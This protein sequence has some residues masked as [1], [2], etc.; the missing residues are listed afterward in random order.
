MNA[1]AS[2]AQRLPAPRGR[3]RAPGTP[4]HRPGLVSAHARA[5]LVQRLPAPLG[6]SCE[7]DTPVHRPGSV[8]THA[9]ASLAQRLPAIRGSPRAPPGAA[10]ARPA[11]PP[12]RPGS[13]KT[14]A[15]KQPSATAVLRLKKSRLS[16]PG[17]E[18]LSQGTI[19][20]AKLAYGSWLVAHRLRQGGRRA[21]ANARSVAAL[22]VRAC[23]W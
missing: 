20:A 18:K 3:P 17:T 14:H 2:L 21:A 5:S 13:V 10:P 12:H 7:S 23:A 11:A 16:A 19:C 8:N 22:G 9:R 4:A 15:R 1:L 6:S